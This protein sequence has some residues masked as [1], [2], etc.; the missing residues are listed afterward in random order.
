MKMYVQTAVIHLIPRCCL[1]CNDFGAQSV[2]IAESDAWVTEYQGN[3]KRYPPKET[4]FMAIK[5]RSNILKIWDDPRQMKLNLACGQDIR[6]IQKNW[7]NVDIVAGTNVLQMN[8][9]ELPWPFESDSFDYILARHVLEHVPY[10]IPKY[11]YE[12]NFLQ[13]FMEEIW[14]VMKVGGILDIEV[15]G[16]ISSLT[17]AMDHKR[18]ITPESLHVF[19]GNDKYSYYTS[20]R[21]ELVSVNQSEPFRFKILK[22][23]AYE[24]FDIDIT[25]LRSHTVRFFLRKL[26]PEGKIWT[27][28][29]IGE[30]CG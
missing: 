17:N 23:F 19:Y 16:G 7:V 14:R 13:L 18:I 11:G 30:E 20:C 8:I 3:R 4:I 21:F 9:F 6:P 10:N 27:K 12:H 15:P 24:M 29:R 25:H 1:L 2:H 26:P 5:K 22:V 28:S